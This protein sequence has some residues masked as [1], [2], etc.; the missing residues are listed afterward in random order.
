MDMC[1]K[2]DLIKERCFINAL[3]QNANLLSQSRYCIIIS[4]TKHFTSAELIQNA[5]R[6]VKIIPSLQNSNII[7]AGELLNII[8][9]KSV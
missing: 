9:S 2:F 1:R 3:L 8:A 7:Q 5:L 4:Q 6:S